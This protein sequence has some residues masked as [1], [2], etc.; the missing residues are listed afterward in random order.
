MLNKSIFFVCLFSVTVS[1]GYAQ[2]L[3]NKIALGLNFVKNEHNGD[4]GSGIFNF[5]GKIF[6]LLSESLWQS[7]WLLQ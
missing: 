6:S 5:N 4:Y 7:I 1:F 2:S 3:E